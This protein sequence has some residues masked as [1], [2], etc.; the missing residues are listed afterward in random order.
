M[1]SSS[2]LLLL[3]LWVWSLN[4][5]CAEEVEPG[6]KGV[7]NGRCLRVN[8]GYCVPREGGGGGGYVCRMSG[9]Y[10]LQLIWTT[11]LAG[12]G[13]SVMTA[14]TSIW[15]VRSYL[16][17]KQVAGLLRGNIP[18]SVETLVVLTTVGHGL[19][20]STAIRAKLHQQCSCQR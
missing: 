5:L 10:S 9:W 7:V 3:L 2:P 18:P 6:E 13:S 1:N 4:V 14:I 19:G 15:L 8:P 12:K 17:E 11:S 16:Q 20:M